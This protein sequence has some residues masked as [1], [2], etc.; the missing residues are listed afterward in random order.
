MCFQELACFRC[1]FGYRRVKFALPLNF[2]VPKLALIVY[3]GVL[4]KAY[5]QNSLDALFGSILDS[6]IRS[7]SEEHVFFFT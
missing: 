5:P 2:S 3:V 1:A 4:S 7:G 6:N